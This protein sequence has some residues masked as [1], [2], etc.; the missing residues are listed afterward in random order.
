MVIVVGVDNKL[1]AVTVHV[2][3]AGAGPS[4]FTETTD[5]PR[6]VIVDGRHF[7]VTT[8]ASTF[9]VTVF[10]VPSVTADRMTD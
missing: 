4:R 5:V 9:N 2:N 3:P 1:E 7:K 10:G 8:G 6:L